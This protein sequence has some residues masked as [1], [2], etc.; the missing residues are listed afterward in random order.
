MKGCD[1]LVDHI[2]PRSAPRGDHR[3][4]GGLGFLIK[5]QVTVGAAAGRGGGC[6]V[7]YVL[8]LIMI[9]GSFTCNGKLY[10]IG[11]VWP[12]NYSA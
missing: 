9:V 8:M 1:V 12:Q 6:V 4:G 2:L 5:V 7:V 11:A 10:I 3:P